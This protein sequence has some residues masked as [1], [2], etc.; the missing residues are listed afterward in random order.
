MAEKTLRRNVLQSVEKFLDLSGMS[1]TKF[2]YVSCG[3]PG[4]VRKLRNGR[5]FRA[6]T[7][8]EALRFLGRNRKNKNQRYRG[9][10]S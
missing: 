8:E 2:G 7:L 4:F 6:S 5:D 3:D 10:Q 1:A 9:I